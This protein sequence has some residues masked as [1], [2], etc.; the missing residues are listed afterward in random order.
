MYMTLDVG[1]SLINSFQENELYFDRVK[2]IHL[3]DN[4]KDKDSHLGLGNG[5]I[6]FKTVI[7]LFEK[8]SYDGIY[9]V[10]EIN[11]K[12]SIE[13]SFELLKKLK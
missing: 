4:F 6:D 13:S 5:A 7:N 9:Y 11:D 10:I 8:N 3:S 2:H 1:H 12:N